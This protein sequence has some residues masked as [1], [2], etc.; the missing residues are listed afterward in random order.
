M[1]RTRHIHELNEG[2]TLVTQKTVLS[3]SGKT[4]NHLSEQLHDTLVQ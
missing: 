1:I 3:P 4:T 2:H